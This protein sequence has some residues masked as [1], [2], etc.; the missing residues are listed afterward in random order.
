MRKHN[1]LVANRNADEDELR[2]I[3]V[4]GARARHT[5]D[6]HEENHIYYD[7]ND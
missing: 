7:H 4:F 6:C 5:L 3:F 2:V 1:S